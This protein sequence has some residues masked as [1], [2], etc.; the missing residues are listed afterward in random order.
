MEHATQQHK[1]GMLA[2]L[3]LS[4]AEV[5]AICA[6]F[7]QPK[8]FTHV[9]VV[10]AHNGPS[11]TVVACSEQ[12]VAPLLGALKASGG[13][14]MQL[15]VAGG[16]HSRFMESAQKQFQ[17]CFAQVSIRAPRAPIIGNRDGELLTSASSIEQELRG[18]ICAAVEWWAGM[19]HFLSCDVIIQI[20]PGKTFSNILRRHWPEKRI[21]SFN[22]GADLAPIM[23]VLQTWRSTRQEEQA[24]Q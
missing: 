3:G 12:L 19:R 20:G 23:Q 10:A 5:R 16:F 2:V 9:A 18:Q 7:D 22:D 24:W 14:A 4:S 1:G 17:D 15:P 13:R 21:L 8:T 11:H 6:T